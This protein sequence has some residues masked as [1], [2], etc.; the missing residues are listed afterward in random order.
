M[1]PCFMEQ[2]CRAEARS[3][4]PKSKAIRNDN[5]TSKVLV[6]ALAARPIR[7]KRQPDAEPFDDLAM[8]TDRPASTGLVAAG[9]DRLGSPHGWDAGHDQQ[10]QH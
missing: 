10:D 9:F 8:P 1:L 4:K 7:R 3:R 2:K 5:S 6:T